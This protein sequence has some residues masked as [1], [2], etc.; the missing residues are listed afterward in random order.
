[1]NV[2]KPVLSLVDPRL[3]NGEVERLDDTS[4][5][6][7]VSSGNVQAFETLVTR[8]EANMRRYLQRMVGDE[9][10][11]D[12]CQETFVQI[13]QR[14]ENYRESGKFKVMLYTIA[15]RKALS[16]L[17]WRRVRSVFQAAETAREKDQPTVRE[18]GDLEQLLQIERNQQL[19]CQL[20]KLPKKLREAVVLHYAEGLDYQAISDVTGE[21]LGTLRARAHRGLAQL[22]ERLARLEE[23]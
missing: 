3:Q 15:R 4:L 9:N 23:K 1:M 20:Q 6:S 14:R 13:W 16:H 18:A 21:P 10:A 11:A 7:L 12:L 5:M 22:R 8:H 2:E 17:R 19:N